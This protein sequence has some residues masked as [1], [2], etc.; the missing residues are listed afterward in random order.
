MMYNEH[1]KPCLPIENDDSREALEWNLEVY[2]DRQRW[3]A[4]LVRRLQHELSF[5]KRQLQDAREWNLE[6]MSADDLRT[7]AAV[8]LDMLE[9]VFKLV[10]KTSSEIIGLEI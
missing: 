8:S 6:E 5:D 4:S 1:G 9:A 3:M 10:D 2:D 7:A